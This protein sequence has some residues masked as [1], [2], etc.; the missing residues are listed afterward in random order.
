MARLTRLPRLKRLLH[1]QTGV[2]AIEFA[3]IAP[4]LTIA[5]ICM[6]DI[7][8]V[9]YDQMRMGQIV[10]EVAAA[11]MAQPFG[12]NFDIIQ[13]HEVQVVGTPV[14]GGTFTVS[15]ISREFRCAG[16]V[17]APSPNQ[18]C[19]DGMEP[20]IFLVISASFVSRPFLLPARTFTNSM[21]VAVR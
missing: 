14:G 1:D 5:F 2:A 8:I 6:I 13:A 7:G 18:L 9:I 21:T 17:P 11:V 12:S 3:L 4:V 16:G 10:R 15:P 19:A 20:R